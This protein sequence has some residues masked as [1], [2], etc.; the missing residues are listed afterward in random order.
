[1]RRD[2]LYRAEGIVLRQFRLGEADRIITL[3]TAEHGKLRA[4]AKGVRKTRSRLAGHLEPLT[5]VQVQVARGKSLDIISQAVTVDAHMPLRIDLWRMTCALYMAE[6]VDRF[7]EESSFDRAES[8]AMYGLFASSLRWLTMAASIDVVLRFFE[9]HLLDHAGYRPEFD[10]C[11]RCSRPA[12]SG[13]AYRFRAGE[14]GIVCGDCAEHGG[15]R[16]LSP[17][18][19]ETI[20]ALSAASP[21]EADILDMTGGIHVEIEAVLRD[22]IRHLLARELNSTSL[23]EE[24]RLENTE[25]GGQDRAAATLAGR[26]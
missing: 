6:L 19:I 3:F 20:Q 13:R 4:V 17:Q 5:R 12:V 15:G 2:R 10:R 22:Y 8:H 18:A 16:S 14:G 26:P 24:L 21:L 23:M 11:I 7:W 1:M 25:R 9:V